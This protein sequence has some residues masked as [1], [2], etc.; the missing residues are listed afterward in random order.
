MHNG[1][2]IPAP[3]AGA[4]RLHVPQ[5]AW[6][7]F[8][9]AVGD[10]SSFFGLGVGPAQL[11]VPASSAAPSSD[12][13]LAGGVDLDG[14][15]RKA[16]GAFE[17][18]LP[19]ERLMCGA[20]RRARALCSFGAAATQHAS[21]HSAVAFGAFSRHLGGPWLEKTEYVSRSRSRD[22]RPQAR[23]PYTITKQ[24]ERWTED[25]HKLFLEALRLH[26]RAWRKIEGEEARLGPAQW[27]RRTLVGDKLTCSLNAAALAEHVGTKTAVQIRSH[28][29]KFFSK[30]RPADVLLYCPLNLC[31]AGLWDTCGCPRY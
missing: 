3:L 12:S 14:H 22:A 16:R 7:P 15:P 30:V 8:A 26:G 19:D 10:P 20:E 24:R 21:G 31:A 25:E 11:A 13:Q 9:A 27:L 2:G 5:F 6:P 23:K 17:R 29:Q 1:D 28:A 4:G 18:K